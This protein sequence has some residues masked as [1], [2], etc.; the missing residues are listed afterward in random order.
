MHAVTTIADRSEPP[1]S[2]PD[3]PVMR[4]VIVVLAQCVADQG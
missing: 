4:M 2:S 3:D 1:A